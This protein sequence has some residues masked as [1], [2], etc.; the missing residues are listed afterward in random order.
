MKNLPISYDTQ[1]LHCNYLN[2]KAKNIFSLPIY[3]SIKNH[4][5]ESIIQNINK[6]ASTNI[7]VAITG[8]AGPKGGGKK[9]P[10]GLVYIG[11]KKNNKINLKKYLFRN[12]GRLYIQKAAVK[13][14]L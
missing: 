13:K 8:I 11:I 6:I 5:I 9:K 1:L 2:L 14:S 3:P 12:K 7:S 10:I 4:E